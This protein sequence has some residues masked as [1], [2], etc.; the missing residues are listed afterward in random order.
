MA[1]MDISYS[2]HANLRG[3]QPKSIRSK[4]DFW[5]IIGTNAARI[6][7][8]DDDNFIGTPQWCPQNNVSKQL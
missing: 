7:E 2:L 4:C 1:F 6:L 3:H 8:Y 5:S